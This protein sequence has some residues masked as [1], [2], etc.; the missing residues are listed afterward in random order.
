ML[1]KIPRHFQTALFPIIVLAVVAN[2]PISRAQQTLLSPS[3]L[4]L[5]FHLAIELFWGDE[6]RSLDRCS[7]WCL[8]RLLAHGDGYGSGRIFTEAFCKVV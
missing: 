6:T 8:V 5:L 2:F 3:R 4:L 1:S 7:E